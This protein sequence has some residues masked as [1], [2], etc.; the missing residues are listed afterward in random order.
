M[1][2][3]CKIATKEEVLKQFDYEISIHKGD[4]NWV[5][6][7]EERRN[8]PDGNIITYFG[9]LDGNTICEA[10]AAITKDYVQNSDGLVDDKTA[11][12]FAFR[13]KKDYRK[14]GYFSKLFK[15]MINDLKSRGYTKVTVGVE[16]DE[17]D[18]KAIYFHYGFNEYIK[19][20]YEIEPDGTKVMV[21]YFSKKI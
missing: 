15:Y 21:E 19:N 9:I 17:L 11:Y 8:T 5:E 7:K 16:P 6:W 14:Q 3:I 2:Y 12:L 13:T 18:N 10:S 1:S 4:N 20:D